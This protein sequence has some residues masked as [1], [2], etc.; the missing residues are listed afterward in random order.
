MADDQYDDLPK[1][2]TLVAEP[3]AEDSYDDLPSGAKLAAPAKTAPPVPQ[4]PPAPAAPRQPDT[5][6]AAPKPTLFQRARQ[7]VGNSIIGDALQSTMPKVA[8]A[9]GLQPT[10]TEA[11]QQRTGDNSQMPR[12]PD[13]A[14]TPIIDKV[15]QAGERIDRALG[16]GPEIDRRKAALAEFDKSHPYQAKVAEGLHESI[17]GLTTPA[18]LALLAV[19]PEAK[20]V[21]AFFALQAARGSYDTAEAGYQAWRRGENPEAAKYLTESGLSAAIAGMAGTHAL[22]DAFPVDTARPRVSD[23]RVEIPVEPKALP[24]PPPPVEAEYVGQPPASAPEAGPAPREAEFSDLP[25]GAK[26]VTPEPPKAPV[27]DE[28]LATAEAALTGKPIEEG[29]ER[30]AVQASQNPADLRKSAKG[31]QPDLEKMAH[32]VADQVPGAEVVGPRVKSEESIENKDERGK[33]P[34][35]NI[36]NLGVRVVAPNPDAVPEIQKA[37]ESQLPVVQKDTITNNGL[38]VPQYGVKTGEPG[39]PNQV[40]EL[41]IPTAAEA[42]AMKDTDELY[43]K[44]KDALVSGDK[45]KADKLGAEI[46]QTFDE[47]RKIEAGENGG[48]GGR[49]QSPEQAGGATAP[50]Q[51]LSKGVEVQ[52]PDGRQGVIKGGNSNFSNGGRW[53]VQTPDGEKVFKGADLK[54]IEQPKAAPA[55]STPPTKGDQWIGVDLDGTLAHY[56]GF[57]GKTVIGAPVP[58]MVDR[59]KQSIADGNKVKI[60]TARVSE[61]P[62]GEARKAIED[63]TEKH[64]GKRLEVTDVKDSHMTHLYDDRAVPVERNTG[65]LLAEPQS[66]TSVP[67]TTTADNGHKSDNVVSTPD[68]RVN[69]ELRKRVEQMSPEEMKRTLLTSEKTGLPNRRAFDEAEHR[70][71]APVVAMSDADGLKAF[72]DKFGYEK[73]DELLKAKAEALRQAGVEAYHD[74]GDEFLYRADEPASLNGK[75]EKARE[76]LRN[77]E[78]SVT[79]D[80]EPVTLKG[81]DFSY[82]TGKDLVAAEQALKA[83]KSE[84]EAN[85]QRARGELRGLTQTE[86]GAGGEGNAKE[87]ADAERN[88]TEQPTAAVTDRRGEE[89]GHAVRE[90]EA[91]PVLQREPEQAGEAGSGRGRV[92]PVEQGAQAAREGAEPAGQ[93]DAGQKEVVAKPPQ[94]EENVS[95]APGGRKAGERRETPDTRGG[96][97]NELAAKPGAIRER[98]GE[99]GQAPGAGEG[100]RSELPKGA[101]PVPGARPEPGPG[102][103]S[104]SALDQSPA[105]RVVEKANKELRKIPVLN[106]D[107]YVHPADWKVPGGEVTRLDN[108]I[109]ALRLLREVQKA[110]RVLTADEK[111]ILANYVG[112]G[113]LP[114]AFDPYR[115][116]YNEQTRWRKANEALREL[117]SSEEYD[118]ARRSTQNAHYTSPDVVR[119]MWE[120]AQRFGFKSGNVLEPSMG[121]GNFFG[122]MPKSIRGK[123]NA[124]GNELE[125]ITH[126]I[127]QLLYPGATIFNKD[128]VQLIIPDNEFDFAIGN[129][130]FGEAVYDPKYP[131]LK[132]RIHDYFFVKTLDKVKPGGVIAYITS[133]GTMDKEN[134]TIRT[135]LANQA[136]LVG[137]FR[138]PSNAFKQAA[139]TSVTTDLI[140][141]RKRLPGEAPSGPAWMNAPELK[142]MKEDNSGLHSL[143]VNEYFQA[144]P[145]H[146]LG[147]P[148]ASTRMYG[149]L[150]FMLKPYDN[151]LPELLEKAL[152]KLPK[153]IMRD[154]DS[155]PSGLDQAATT[156]PYAPDNVQEKQYIL[157]KDGNLRQ[158]VNGKLVSPAVVEGK[159]GTKSLTKVDRIKKMVGLRDVLNSL[160][161]SMIT[162]PDDE[163]AN[164]AIA[165]TRGDLE[166]AYNAFVKKYGYLNS[167]SNNIF[168]DDP[169]YPRLLALEH[170]DRATRKGTPADIFRKRTIFPREPLKAV[171]KDPK[172]ALQQI[173]G[174]RGYPDVRLIAELQGKTPEEVAAELVKQGLIFR[175][176]EVGDYQTREKYLSGYVRDKLD[177]ARE[178]VKQGAKEYQVNVDA[179]EKVIPEDVEITGDPKTGASVRLGA[180]WIPIPAIE[181]F[182]RD[183]FK[184]NAKVKYQD[185]IWSVDAGRYTPE[186]TSVFGTP[187]AS[188]DWL[189][190]QSLNQK[191]ALVYDKNADGNPVLNQEQT[192]LAQAAQEKIREEFQKWAAKSKW[193]PQLQKAYN[194]A[195]NN[196]VSTEYDGSHLS[197]P[198]MNS[199][200]T[201]KSHQVNAVWRI[202]QD[203]RGLLA[204]EVGAGKTFEMAAAIMEGRRVGTFKKPMLTVPNHIVEQFRKEFLLLYPGANLLVPSEKD[205]DS[206]NRQRIMSHIATGNYDA[207]ILPHSQF[208]L[209]DISPERQAITIQRQLDEL[210]ETI[211]AVKA[212]NGEKRTVKQLEKSKEKLRT[213][214]AQL[215]DLRADRAINFDDTGV[216]ALFVDEAHAFKNLSYYTKMTRV[217]GLQQARAKSALRLK[218][219]TEYLQE[220]NRGRGVI[221]A[222]GTPVQNTMAEL[223]TM[224][225]YV[226][227]DVLEKAGIRFFDDWAANF[228]STITAMELSADGR[229]YKARTKFAR[230]QNVP[231][232][233]QMFRSFADV[234]TAADL[235]LPRPELEG[236]RPTIIT[237]PASPELEQYVADL[238][239]RAD[240]VRK[241]NVNPKQDNMLKVTT[242]GR[243]AATDMRLID[244]Q[245]FADDADSKINTAVG[246]MVDEWREGKE[247]K[248]TQMAFLDMYRSIDDNDNELVNLY[249]DMRDKLIASGIPREEI[250]LVNEYDTRIKRQNLFE[251]VNKG[252]VRILLGSTQ[253][254]GAGTNAQTLLKALHHIDLTW[255]PGDL[256]QRE[257]RILRQGNKNATVRIY[258]YLTA[259]SFDAYMAQTLQSKAEFISQILSGK[260][261]DR[262]MVDAAAD[263]VLSLEEMK[264]AASGN[265]DVKLKYDLELKRSQLLT[266]ERGW[267]EQIRTN[268]Y[269]AERANDRAAKLEGE[270]SLVEKTMKEI[271]KVKG[272]DGKGFFM[273]VDGKKFTDRA[274][275]FK[276][277]EAMK[278][279]PVPF[280]MEI[281]GVQVHAEPPKTGNNGSDQIWYTPSYAVRG[282]LAPE[283]NMK[284]LGMSL[285]SRLRNLNDDIEEKRGAIKRAREDAEKFEKLSKDGSF[286]EKAELAEVNRQIAEVEKRLGLGN[287]NAGSQ[288][289]AEGAV[290][291]VEAETPDKEPAEVEEEDEDSEEEIGESRQPEPPSSLGSTLYAGFADPELF[292]Q[293]FPDIVRRMADWVSEEV[294]HADIQREMMRDTRGQ[295]DRRVA[296][297][298]HHLK[299]ASKSWRTRSREDSKKFWNAVEEGNI[300]SLDAKDQALA[301]VFRNAFDQLKGEIQQLKPEVLQN[302][303]ENY[304]PHI[305]EKPA[306]VT[307]ALRR[308]LNGKRPFAG[309]AS[310]LKE[311]KI[312]TMQEGIDL[313]FKPKSWNPVDLFLM[314][315]AEMAQFLMGHQTLQTMKDS[316]TARFVRIGRKAPEGWTQL[317]DRIGTVYGRER[318]VDEDKVADATF[319]KTYPGGKRATPSIA[320]EDLEDATTPVTVIRGHYYA[321]AE[322]AR[323]FNNFVSKGIAGRSMIYDTLNWMN[324]NLNAVQLGISA[325]HASTTTINAAT[326]DVALG[327]QQLAEGKPL[328]A[329]ASLAK[330]LT[331]APSMLRTLVNGSRMLRQYLEPGSY[332]KMAKEAQALAQA[333]GRVR[334][335]T[336]ELKPLQKVAN[337]WRNGAVLEGLTSIPGAIMHATVA[338]V[339]EFYVPRMKLGAF[340]AMAHDILDESSRR[341]WSPDKTRA[342]M[343]EAWDSIDNRFG[344]VVYDNLFWHKATRDVLQLATRSVGW[345]FGSVR[346]VGGGIGDAAKAAG[347]AATGK[348]PRITPR[349]AFAM[350]LPM[351]S[352]LVGGILTYLWT[353]Q[354]PQNWKD[355]FY[356]KS[357]DGERHSIPGYMKDV[358][359]F[360]HDPIRTA[361]NKMAPIW[362]MTS[363]AIQNRDFYSTEIRHKDDP[364]MKQLAEFAS[365]AT[366]QTIPFSFSGA[367]KLLSQ[368]GAGPSLGEMLHEAKKYPGD[369]AL[370]QLGFQPAPSTIQ[371]SAA[372]NLAHEY[373][374]ENRPP[375]TKT[376]EQSA[377][378]AAM[379]AV[380][381]M[382]RTDEVDQ[383][384]IDKYIDKGVLTEKDVRKAEQE[385][386]EDPLARVVKNLSL[387]QMLNVWGKADETERDAIEPI[388]ERHERDID[389]IS[390]DEERERLQDAFDKVMGEPE[391]A[392]APGGGA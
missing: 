223:Y 235:N 307:R 253:K 203:G 242:D 263:M 382:Y 333:G 116:N 62:G 200:I 264:I 292:Q 84:R 105:L 102:E 260:A 171:S 37:V 319:D 390:D 148:V 108:N 74:K 322:A 303:I 82:G 320:I 28:K 67:Q 237:V 186:M 164:A 38:N 355:Y 86:T 272:A 20:P 367:A 89:E 93:T 70:N 392:T 267:E 156:A 387:Q 137:A 324:Q 368:R 63:W 381:R 321:P 169:H 174:E 359:S 234:K 193:K 160:M 189:T 22:K 6:Q 113:S 212:A 181:D 45:A 34:E 214:L 282:F 208:N 142:V 30:P 44:Q 262:V 138:L 240:A 15:S 248:L 49:G 11:E 57:K 100:D 85:G 123:V 271:E 106:K 383:E 218:M 54:R 286:P 285:E 379:D 10:E 9:L 178:A 353:G 55:N 388:I 345:N 213:S 126:G 32:A 96:D 354:P 23:P 112:W 48:N 2:A 133:T 165:Q 334:Q 170:Y 275:A 162:M 250:A 377:H 220:K 31:Q 41:Q 151:P 56:D 90:P 245:V 330:G 261:K 300:R 378:Y 336:L 225:K 241:G 136:D 47:A 159:D 310:F 360:A 287:V 293:L 185:G 364:L 280:F 73:G 216:D 352:A 311:R 60:L 391:A 65:K 175:D 296:V 306:L 295:M 278:L 42:Q 366:K 183:T 217:A 194:Y 147:K 110:P 374:M 130:P 180:T 238:M 279:P 341:G 326:S 327:I 205:F 227:P 80:G 64:L 375:G 277:L 95:H 77:R 117:L 337:A 385:S 87:V 143:N 318:A 166:K 329:G 206:K 325:F 72:N 373:S 79:V 21:S 251:K 172:E 83:H 362:E 201:L 124:V 274:E 358:F 78:F 304:F 177:A 361:L 243:K 372:M 17:A 357:S 127:A 187:R 339:M 157:D 276:Y 239:D 232:L 188:G 294:N 356:P 258:N 338:P 109:A 61:D 207:I 191:Q 340:Y 369:V 323:V 58:A 299:D 291:D 104:D 168:Q 68:R 288:A 316:G 269:N 24:A 230:F 19:A 380:V 122:M 313:G 197:F 94:P 135:V 228:G 97:R 145:D 43:A 53:N 255:R 252:E 376:Q 35:S 298:M 98:P 1:G 184:T 244:H 308:L 346:E 256:S 273:N 328:K 370:G 204:H 7:S 331:V 5:I 190:Q 71:P 246:K 115:V 192:T 91:A 50:L 18:N 152:Q 343:Q 154:M 344:Q 314:K 309:R 297:A 290:A 265:P 215:Q 46:Q 111:Q 52:L 198:G 259:K 219:K 347:Q 134:P 59:I 131:K 101:E 236:G 66:E 125:P 202:L 350:A 120:I 150:D 103:G 39:E 305:W 229:S 51:P 332:A 140:I 173:L 266:M 129:V 182:I 365:W 25:K 233:M 118:A 29:G 161:T 231:E 40:S 167:P 121:S 386:N 13:W 249:K 226:A 384:Q 281:N 149:G 75:L 210:E 315:Y 8:D 12:L 363:E 163:E 348:M 26:V 283:P 141:L 301:V 107:W 114:N 128:F 139:G 284:S 81:V 153:G 211:R 119:W 132:A 144:H 257:G 195:Y 335:N 247:D 349:M 224:I 317:D 196:L 92:E 176:P 155:K 268:R 312:P 99:E 76:I 14:N 209:M 222:T 33:P 289:E 36:D 389:K 342:R 179:L 254:M 146:M 16:Q 199:A 302:Y 4:T 371:N 3:P 27:P 88:R 221:F 351:V 158:R 270:V 69:T